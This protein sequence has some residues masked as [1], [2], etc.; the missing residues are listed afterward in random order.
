MRRPKVCIVTPALADA[1]NGNWRT[2]KRWAS[3]L[4]DR[5][6]VRLAKNWLPGD[7]G[8][9]LIALHAR[10]S[11]DS[12][13]AWSASCHNCPVIVVLTGTDLYRDIRTDPSAQLSLTLATRLIV[14]QAAGP[15]ELS[16]ALQTKCRV[17]YQS[18]RAR[19][20][21]DKTRRRLRAVVVG[22]LREEKS[23]QT[24]FEAARLLAPAEGI[25]LDH[26]GAALDP[27]LGEQ[28]RATAATC[29]HYRWHGG[30][31][32]SDARHAMQRAHVLVHCSRMEGGAHVILEAVRG[33]TPVIASRI[34]G[35]IGMLGDDYD[36]YFET[37]DAGAL[38]ALLRRARQEQGGTDGL[39]AKLQVQCAARDGL[40]TPGA[41]KAALLAV[42]EDVLKTHR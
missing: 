14:L 34:P 39:L 10:R 7:D 20:P 37:G 9:L 26:Y 40:F 36:G 31:A 11:A 16:P 3:M 13:A 25:V 28:A 8:D 42:I 33:G 19:P 15:R 22:H 18:A 24:I 2:A 12:V 4:A 23:P 6:A 38:V 29:P 17:V 1:N 32:H 30:V 35:N 41:E 5:Y 27:N 21:V